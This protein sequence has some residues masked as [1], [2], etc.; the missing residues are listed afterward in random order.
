MSCAQAGH[1]WKSWQGT[2]EGAVSEEHGMELGAAGVAGGEHWCR[3][4]GVWSAGTSS[5]EAEQQ[6]LGQLMGQVMSWS[7]W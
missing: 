5:C 3:E 6:C 1:M 2:F 4:C 7:C